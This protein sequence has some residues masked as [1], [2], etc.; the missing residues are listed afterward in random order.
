MLRFDHFHDQF[1]SEWARIRP[2]ALDHRTQTNEVGRCAVLL[3]ILAALPQPLALLE[4]GASAGLCLYPDRFS[5][6]FGD[7]PRV[8]PSQGPRAAVLRCNTSG[9]VPVP[10]RLP[11]IVWRA[12]I[13][14]NP[15]DVDNVEQ[16]RWLETLVWPEQEDR[17]DR[18]GVAMEMV[19]RDP[20]IL[21]EGDLLS[22]LDETAATAPDC[23]TLVIFH[24]AVMA[25]LSIE[26]RATFVQMVGDL[27]DHWISNE[28]VGVIPFPNHVLPAP[29]EPTRSTFVV[30]LD[31]VPMAY[32]GSHGQWLEW[33]GP[34]GPG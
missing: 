14:L 1:V 20:P 15:L 23:A 22:L 25:Y 30:A 19:R 10:V 7:R 2:I 24:S 28:G 16:M 11:E 3:P 26:D 18:L 6:Q 33:F 27:P 32:S 34:V 9:T 13:D 31:G 12:G 17:R 29:M 5:Y 8:D 4:V 21:I